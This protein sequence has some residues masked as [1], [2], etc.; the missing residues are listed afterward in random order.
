MREGLASSGGRDFKLGRR[1]CVVVA[2]VKKRLR[3]CVVKGVVGEIELRGLES[4]CTVWSL[5]I[6]GWFFWESN[7]TLSSGRHNPIAPKK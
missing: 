4:A 2:F 5:G 1:M 6:C 7:F 3:G